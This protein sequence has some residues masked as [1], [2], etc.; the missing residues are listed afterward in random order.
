MEFEWLYAIACPACGVCPKTI[1]DYDEL[2]YPRC[3]RCGT[4]I[5]S[6][7]G[8]KGGDGSVAATGTE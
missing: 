3:P 7:V 5:R 8:G 1:T 4:T 6:A 2:G